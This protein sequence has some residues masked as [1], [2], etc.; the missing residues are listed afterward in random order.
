[1]PPYYSLPSG[2]F[3]SLSLELSVMAALK[4]SY[5]QSALPSCGLLRMS[6]RHLPSS[7]WHRHTAAPMPAPFPKTGGH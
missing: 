3:T 6:I 2:A 7:G 1:M 5:C 4:N